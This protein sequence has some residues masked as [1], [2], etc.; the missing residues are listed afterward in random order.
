MPHPHK[1]KFSTS[2]PF[3]AVTLAMLVLAAALALVIF[4]PILS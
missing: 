4:T 3:D 1:S 2:H